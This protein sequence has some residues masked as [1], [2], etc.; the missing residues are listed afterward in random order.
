MNVGD[1]VKHSWCHLGLGIVV[2]WYDSVNGYLIVRWRTAENP[3]HISKLILVS[4]AVNKE[5]T[6]NIDEHV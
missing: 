3:C 4:K 2:G 6:G 5:T 1:L